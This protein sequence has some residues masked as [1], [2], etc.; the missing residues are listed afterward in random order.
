MDRWEL[1]EIAPSSIKYDR[2]NDGD[3]DNGNDVQDD[4]EDVD[5]DDDNGNDED[6]RKTILFNYDYKDSVGLRW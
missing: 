5:N 2:H 3:D 6:S 1:K 4:D